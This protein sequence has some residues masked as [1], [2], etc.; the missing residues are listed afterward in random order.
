MPSKNS[1]LK[2]RIQTIKEKVFELKQISEEMVES[3]T[4]Q[5]LSEAV[6]KVENALHKGVI[7][8]KK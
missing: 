5:S 1:K 4:L 8:F 3:T 2:G 7:K 6:D